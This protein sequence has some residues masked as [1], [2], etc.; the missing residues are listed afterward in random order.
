MTSLIKVLDSTSINIGFL[1]ITVQSICYF[2][3]SYVFP[4]GPW[5]A[6]PG[7][8]A[9][10]FV[11][12]PL[13]IFL[14]VIGWSTWFT[15]EGNEGYSTPLERV[16]KVH[17]VGRQ[18][19]GII[20]CQLLL[21]DVPIGLLTKTLRQPEMIL[22]H[23]LMLILAYM[24][25]KFNM[26][27]YYT[28]LYFGA[29]ELSGVPLALVDL[30]HPRHQPWCTFFEQHP[31]LAI[32]PQISRPAFAVLYFI[33]RMFIFPYYMF[34]MVLPD[35]YDLLSEGSDMAA[36]LIVV[37]IFAILLTLLQLYWGLLIAQQVMKMF[38]S[39]SSLKKITKNKVR[40]E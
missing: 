24:S 5:K 39:S 1:C 35:I 31:N 19:S 21:W 13:M 12:L 8:T 36:S 17:E 32:L 40:E 15:T 3:F 29:I 38:N 26:F 18:L 6:E 28:P 27:T 30:T 22:H 7:F 23:V 25:F 4:K 33:C 9:H 16:S 34:G 11:A 10:Q 37:G 2:L 20:F 14:S